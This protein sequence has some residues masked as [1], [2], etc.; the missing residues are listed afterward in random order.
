MFLV[1]PL[2]GMRL[3]VHAAARLAC[4]V[5]S[6]EFSVTEEKAMDELCYSERMR[7]LRHGWR[8]SLIVAGQGVPALTGGIAPASEGGGERG[9]S[10]SGHVACDQ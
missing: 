3:N 1:L 8:R 6:C 10:Q 9:G 2:G 5:P 4:A 7:G